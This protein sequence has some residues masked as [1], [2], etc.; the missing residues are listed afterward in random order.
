MIS[1]IIR[2]LNEEKYL[3]ELLKTIDSQIIDQSVEKI[4]VD[5]GSTDGTLE[6]AKKF[7]CRI[8][9]ID[10][11]DFTFGKSLNDG[12]IFS[13]GDILVFIS[14]H[15]IPDSNFWLSNL[16]VNLVNGSADYVYGRQ[17]GRD[18]TKFSEEVLF[19][20]YYPNHNNPDN[21]KY[22]C[23]NANS[24]IKR[25]VWEK[26]MFNEKLTGLEDMGLAKKIF[27]DGGSI[28]YSPKASVYHIHDETFKQVKIRY[29]REAI[30]LKE[31][32]PEI[33]ISIIDLIRYIF[34]AIF[35]DS[36]YALNQKKL[37]KNFFSIVMFRFSQ[38][39]G[40]YIGS[41]KKLL[42]NELHKNK[43]KYFYPK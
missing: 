7:K 39:Y 4:I 35:L 17:L 24:A 36:L 42:K 37:T 30:A 43:E 41:N 5:S 40:S 38:Y 22:F 19:Q 26:Y 27:E 1:V 25:P 9:F 28:Q 15:C 33:Q 34:T 14:G 12:C 2:T 8:T 16:I 6:I 3:P 13:K 29:E 18:S 21:P 20:K 11:K 23:N 10:K 32:M 31:I